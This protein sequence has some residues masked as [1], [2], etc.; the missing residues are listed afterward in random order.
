MRKYVF[1][2]K[3]NSEDRDC[4]AYIKNKPMRFECG[5]Y[6]ESVGLSGACYSG[7]KFA[8]YEDI[9]TVLTKEEYKALIDFSK[10]IGDLG[11]GIAEG[12]ERYNEGVELCNG[13]Q[14]VYDKL[15]SEENKALFD[16]V[17]EEEKEY[18]MDEY[19]LDENDVEYIFD[20]YGL[21]YK[22]RSVVGCVYD[23]AY[24]LGYEEAYGLGYVNN[25]DDIVE[26]YFNFEKFGQDL[27]E[28]KQYLELNDGRCVYLMY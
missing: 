26:R 8:D 16:E 28:D 25:N 9:K 5:H 22:D 20:N 17:W 19:G 18:L 14:Y 24:D 6:F 2:Y 3:D 10:A 1:L 4:C 23:N 27:L 11:Y 13:I 12:D 7:H 15:L 21:E